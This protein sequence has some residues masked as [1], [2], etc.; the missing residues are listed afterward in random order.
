ML[1]TTVRP[2]ILCHVYPPP[3]S[4][5]NMEISGSKKQQQQKKDS[6]SWFTLGTNNPPLQQ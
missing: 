1:L 6:D 4:H 5:P 2:W 3:T